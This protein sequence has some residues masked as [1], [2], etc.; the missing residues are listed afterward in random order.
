MTLR[1]RQ[2]RI[3]DAKHLAWIRTLPCLVTGKTGDIHAAHIRFASVKYNKRQTGIGEKSS[4]CWVVPLNAN[5][6][7]NGQHREGERTW[8][9]SL[10]IDPL[11]AAQRLYS[12][13]GKTQKAIEFMDKARRVSV[14]NTSADR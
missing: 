6:H 13:S 9:F 5:L 14:I 11:K 1:Q 3:E 7:L 12:L 4:D 2:P 10:G 8:W